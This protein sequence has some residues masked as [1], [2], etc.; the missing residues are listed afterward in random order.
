MKKY[1]IF[2]V[3]NEGYSP[4]LKMLLGSIVDKVDLER[5]NKI[6]V[7]DTGLSENTKNYIRQF[8]KLEIYNTNVS[9][10][11]SRI[12]DDDW[13]KNV[14]SKAK[15]LL[16]SIEA[17]P[18]FT[19]T[20]MIDVDCIIVG[21]FIELLDENADVIACLRN[22]AGRTPGHQA[23]S[24]HIGSFFVVNKENCKE[25][26]KYWIDEIPKITT[27]GPDGKRIPQESPALSNACDIFKKKIR[28]VDLDER[29]IANI[30]GDPP[31]FARLY[32]LKSDWQFPTIEKRITQPR[33]MYYAGRYL[34]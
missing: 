6:I 26:M 14:Y 18:Q 24:S 11:Y 7:A 33:A 16:G 4:F 15:F 28:I 10:H 1:N 19:S 27:I 32:H 23:T 9:T 20:I 29:V 31:P 12:H 3:S 34:R 17:E 13:K 2:T 5:I 25:F 8:P 22:Q 30:E 21:D